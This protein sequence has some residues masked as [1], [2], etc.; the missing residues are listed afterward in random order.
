MH[1]VGMAQRLDEHALARVDQ[2]HGQIGGRCAGRHIA[3]VLLV[4]GRVGDNKFAPG[5]REKP[6]G[7]I[8]GNA[9]LA[10]GF[11]PVQQQG[12]VHFIARCPVLFRIPLEH[13]KLVIKDEPGIVQK[14]PDQR[15]FAVIDR[16]AG[17]QTQHTL[18]CGRAGL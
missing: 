10:L 17:D 1:D 14:P 6:I 16:S 18:R 15:G 5:R 11:Q 8:N 13:G 7:D 3:C 12:E 2:D 4:S 9:L